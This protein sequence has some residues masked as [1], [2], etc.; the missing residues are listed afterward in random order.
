MPNTTFNILDIRRRLGAK[1]WAPPKEWGVDTWVLDS[2]VTDARIIVSDVLAGFVD[3]D[4]DWIHA[5]LSR[6]FRLPIYEEMVELHKAVWP[7]GYSYEVHPPEQDHVNIHAY[8]LHLWGRADGKRA[9]PDFGR[10][11]SI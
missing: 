4:V 9:L 10:F 7:D 1:H 6:R 2:K 8:A 3:N 5:S 11:G